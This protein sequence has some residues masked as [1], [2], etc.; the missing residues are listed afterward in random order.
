[1]ISSLYFAKDKS[2]FEVK[3]IYCV[4]KN[5]L[6]HVKEFANY[7]IP[8][9][10]VI[11]MKPTSALC[12]SGSEV[13]I[14]KIVGQYISEDLQNEVELVIAIGN[15]F[16]NTNY[17]FN[18]VVAGIGI[19]FDMTLRDVQSIAKS[20]GLPWTVSKGFRNSSPV[21]ELFEPELPDSGIEFSINVNGER[22]QHGNS[23]DMLFDFESIMKYINDVFNLQKGDIIFTGT[24][25]GISTLRI[26]D[27]LEG[28][29][30][31]KK[32]LEINIS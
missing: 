17:S 26:G 18:K 31:D 4:G 29:Y 22:R 11:F 2:N 3:N 20:K 5:Y 14:P 8:K 7:E 13:S 1:M 6:D 9:E 12:Q 28:F 24:P 16:S 10:P 21:S 27:F 15:E 23:N 25:S 19:G 30:F 32:V